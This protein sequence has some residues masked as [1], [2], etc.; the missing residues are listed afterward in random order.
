MK[1]EYALSKP[2][3]QA[4]VVKPNGRYTGSVPTAKD[5]LL[6]AMGCCYDSAIIFARMHR[7]MDGLTITCGIR[8]TGSHVQKEVMLSKYAK[9]NGV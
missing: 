7:V 1:C 6:R 9:K 2:I 8:C 5:Q 3:N 4:L